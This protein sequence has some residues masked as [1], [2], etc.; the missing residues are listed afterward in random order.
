MNAG[1]TS[2]I[3]GSSTASVIPHSSDEWA[4]SN[5]TDPQ[6]IISHVEM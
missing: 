2:E 5:C 1:K 4:A 6:S 3:F